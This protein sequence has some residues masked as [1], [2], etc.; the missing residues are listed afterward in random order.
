MAEAVKVMV[1]ARPMNKREIGLN[2]NKVIEVFDDRGEIT[3]TNPSEKE[4]KKTFTYDAVFDENSK[5]SE[6]YEKSAFNI[7]NNIF[8]GYNGTIFAYG[9]TGCGKTFSMMGVPE[10]EQLK[11]IIPRS[12]NHIVALISEA[13]DKN[14]LLRCS[15][16]EIYNENIHDL[17]SDDNTKKM[18]LKQDKKRG[19]LTNFL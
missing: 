9:Q 4:N 11:G 7:V 6:V 5:Q 19:K 18:Q 13:K 2:S 14:F 15:F 1:R 16:I 12:F 17:L 10:N 3:I 8:E